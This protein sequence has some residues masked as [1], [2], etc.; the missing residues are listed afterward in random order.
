MGSNTEQHSALLENLP[1]YTGLYFDGNRV[2]LPSWTNKARESFQYEAYCF[3]QISQNANNGKRTLFIGPGFI[4]RIISREMPHFRK[5]DAIKLDTPSDEP[6]TLTDFFEF[7]S[8]KK[9]RP[10]RKIRGFS[11]LLR[12]MRKRPDFLQQLLQSSLRDFDFEANQIIIPPDSEITI[13]FTSPKWRGGIMFAQDYPPFRLQH[14]RIP[15]ET[16]SLA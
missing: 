6:W 12:E 13:T 11:V 15:K 5:P 2:D 14:M 1:L 7:K 16:T 4:D 8:G 10:S 3:K 9:L